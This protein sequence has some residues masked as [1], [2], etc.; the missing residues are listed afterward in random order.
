MDYDND[1][2]QDNDSE[3]SQQSEYLEGLDDDPNFANIQ[4]EL[5]R[6]LEIYLLKKNMKKKLKNY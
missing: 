4:R 1:H 6:Y 3:E 2:D 5:D